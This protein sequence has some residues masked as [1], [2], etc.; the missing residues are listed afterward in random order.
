[1]LNK[2]GERAN[3]NKFT[4]VRATLTKEGGKNYAFKL[5]IN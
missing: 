2:C 4:G 1:M 3:K 5:T